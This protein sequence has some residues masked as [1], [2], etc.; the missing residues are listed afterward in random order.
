[1]TETVKASDI[2][3]GGNHYKGFKIQPFFFVQENG[4][5]FFQG[6]V[7][8]YVARY[9]KETGKGIQDLENIVHY[10]QLEIE[11]LNSGELKPDGA[12]NTQAGEAAE[13]H[14]L[15]IAQTKVYSS[16]LQPSSSEAPP[17]Y[18]WYAMCEAEKRIASVGI[19]EADASRIP[20]L[21]AFA[22]ALKVFYPSNLLPST[23]E[24]RHKVAR[25]CG[26]YLLGEKFNAQ[27]RAV[28]PFGYLR[29]AEAE[30][31]ELGMWA[32]PN[33]ESQP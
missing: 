3:V 14:S 19:S 28:L 15:A 31:H 25:V 8:K 20:A 7:V 18:A 10:C 9:N 4:M 27:L 21:Q 12:C 33:W 22:T 17:S 11:R 1:M 29:C 16:R 23:Y 5:N 2:Q 32:N 6:N 24:Q 30:L 13:P 26:Q